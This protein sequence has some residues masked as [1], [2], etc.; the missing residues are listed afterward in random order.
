MT[1]NDFSEKTL[2]IIE[3]EQ[4][5]EEMTNVQVVAAKKKA[6]LA[7][8]SQTGNVSHSA[9]AVGMHR[10]THYRWLRT[11]EDYVA[12]YEAAQFEVGDTLEAEAIRRAKENSDTLLIFLLKGFKPEKYKERVYSEITGRLG[13]IPDPGREKLTDE[14]LDALI[15][16][17][18]R[19][20]SDKVH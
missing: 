1:D 20:K 16:A 7:V 10:N 4:A 14:Q 18:E 9:D 8:Y 5:G 6:F 15:K 12:A 11:D 2:A 19:L 17:A 13:R 3:Q